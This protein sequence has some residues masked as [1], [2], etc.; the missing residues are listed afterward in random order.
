MRCVMRN[1]SDGRIDIM[2][3]IDYSQFK[4]K[5]KSDHPNHHVEGSV[6]N[7]VCLL[8]VEQAIFQREDVGCTQTAFFIAC[9]F[10]KDAVAL[11]EDLAFGQDV[12]CFL[13]GLGELLV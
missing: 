6:Q 11:L 12:L 4:S 9:I 8:G 1:I 10:F 7:E 5:N 3:L 13:Q 2:I